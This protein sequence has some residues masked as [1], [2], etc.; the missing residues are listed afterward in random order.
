MTTFT[1]EELLDEAVELLPTRETLSLGH[2]LFGTNW[3][4]VSATNVA[5][6]MNSGAF[7]SSATAYANQAVLVNQL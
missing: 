7:L 6:A 1:S 4:N 2:G 3:A 5:L